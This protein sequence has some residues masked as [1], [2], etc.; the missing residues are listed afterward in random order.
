MGL[1]SEK[2]SLASRES[3][4]PAISALGRDFA[5]EVLSIP[6]MDHQDIALVAVFNRNREAL[7]LRR[8]ADVH[9]AGLWSFPGGKVE[10]G[11]AA[12]HAAMRELAEETGLAA[13]RWKPIG[14]TEHA[15]QDRTLHF[16]LFACCSEGSSELSCE[17]EHAWVAI[18][19]LGDFTMP[20]ANAKLLPMLSTL[21]IAEYLNASE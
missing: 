1:T 18:D 8:S 10:A 13:T 3:P 15:Y 4:L 11:E 7:L 19:A 5:D 6:G 16:H 17:S 20:E 9:C 2:P 12:E 21:A 14:E